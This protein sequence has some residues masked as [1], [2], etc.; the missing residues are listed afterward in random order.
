MRRL[1]LFEFGDQQWFPQ[2]LRDAETA[3]LATAYR[4]L[5]LLL[6]RWAEKLSTLLRPGEPSEILDLCS[7]SGGAMPLMVEE[8]VKRGYDVRATLTDLYPNPKSAEHPRIVWLA[9]P[10][11]AAR[12]PPT[13]AGVRTMF[14][15]F[16]HFRPDA[17]KSILRDAFERRRA[18]CIF[19]S[20]SATPLTAVMMA[21]VPVA[22]LLLMPFARPFRWTYALFTYLIPLTPLI[23]LW[24]GMVSLLRVYS[25]EQMKELTAEFEAPDYAWELGRIEGRSIPGGL[26]YAI[27]RPI[28]QSSTAHPLSVNV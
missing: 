10:V 18:I 14:S 11:D 9:E 5:P 4:F 28:P 24:D 23:V 13:L 3:Y 25:P 15:A 8:L 26:P 27:G 16:H 19:E 2:V 21:G 20:G 7:G 12:V 17:A 22:V 6:G 1:H